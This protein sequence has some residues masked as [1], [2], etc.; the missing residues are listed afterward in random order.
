MVPQGVANYPAALPYVTAVGGT[1]LESDTSSSVTPRGVFETAWS[2]GG[3]G[4]DTQEAPLPYQPSDGCDGRM[5]S[6]ISAD[7]DPS[8]GLSFYDS[9]GGRLARRGGGTSHATPIAAAFEAITGVDGSSPQW[10]YSDAGEPEQ[11]DHGLNW[12]VRR[13]A[14]G[15]LQRGCRLLGADRGRLHL[16]PGRHVALL[17]SVS[18][19]FCGED[20]KTYAK[21]R[22]QHRRRS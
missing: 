20:D 15:S 11:P 19:S 16:R 1:S 6:D 13:S 8:T 9:Q 5:Y 14:L 18:P 17:A 22:D 12:L 4:C 2:D 7:A 21:E 10:A 3:S